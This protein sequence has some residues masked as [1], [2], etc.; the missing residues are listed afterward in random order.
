MKPS[1]LTIRGLI[2]GAV[3]VGEKQQPERDLPDEQRLREREQLRDRRAGVRAARPERRGRGED[4][5]PDEQECV[6]M[7]RR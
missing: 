7:V 3:M 4:A 2:L 1:E 6:Y 5:D